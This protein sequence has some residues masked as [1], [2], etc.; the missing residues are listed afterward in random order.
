M[1]VTIKRKHITIATVVLLLAIALYLNVRTTETHTDIAQE[2]ADI[3]QNDYDTEES[4][5]AIMVS[6]TENNLAKAK[7]NREVVRSK[8][9]ELL[10]KT[11]KDTDISQEAKAK[12]EN[13]LLKMSK[14]MDNEAKCEFLL[15]SKGLGEC[16][17]FISD[18]S[19]NVTVGKSDITPE[20]V[21]KINDII[22][23][24]TGNN[25]IK[26]VEVN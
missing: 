14:D 5:K 19:V 25:N 21:T 26:I 2:V 10:S 4:G 12:A 6:A 7:N 23:E 15:S 13:Q 1:F 24:F 22:Y 17:V 11:L 9:C 18:N 8:A 20:D 16:I 3:H